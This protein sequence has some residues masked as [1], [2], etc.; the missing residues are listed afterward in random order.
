MWSVLEHLYDLHTILNA[1]KKLIKPNGLLFIL[2]PNV[3]SLATRLIREMSPTFAW[4]HLSHFSSKSL[5]YLMAQHGFEQIFFETVI[6]EIDN[7]KSYMSGEY[8][9][10]GFGYPEGL[11]DIITPEYIHKNNLGSRMISV[12]R[13]VE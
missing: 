3:E 12:F 7:I 2:V 4:K 10:H 9:Y 11:F 8:P 13:N 1:I 6:S 5:K